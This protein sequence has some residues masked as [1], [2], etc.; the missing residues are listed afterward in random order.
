ML[1]V[2]YA[3]A[4]APGAVNQDYVI[5]GPGWVA[6]LDGATPAPGVASGCVHDVPWLVRTLAGSVMERIESARTLSEVLAEAIS[7]TMS[8]HAGTCDL[9]D[10]NSPSSTIS[11]L[12][13]TGDQLEYLVLCDSPIGVLHAD[14]TVEVIHDDRTDHLPGGRPYSLAV[15]ESS[16]NRP[17]GF[18]VA[19]TEP[20]AA[21]E[22]LTGVVD[23]AGVRGVGLFTDGVTRLVEWYGRS[24]EELLASASESGP[25]SLLVQ[26]RAAERAYGLPRPGKLHDD[27]TAAWVV[28]VLR[29]A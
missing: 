15:V 14:G 23:V 16:R 9:A 10:P 7:A 28:P 24:W 13:R 8:A 21:S 25:A 6:I 26:V 27:A 19:S 11:I 20:A 1:H 5:A 3:T 22:A 2:S 18:W 12:R 17:G 29:D 4:P